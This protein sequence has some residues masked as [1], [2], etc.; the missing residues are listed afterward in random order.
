MKKLTLQNILL[1]IIAIGIWIIVLQR[2]GVIHKVEQVEA[3][4]SGSV[5]VDNTVDVN[6][7]Q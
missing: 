7:I 4:V 3:D 6:V 2:L 5:D 1:I